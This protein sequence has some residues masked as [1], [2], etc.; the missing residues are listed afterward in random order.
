MTKLNYGKKFSGGSIAS[1][2]YHY[3]RSLDISNFRFRGG[4]INSVPRQ[5]ARW[6]TGQK[7]SNAAKERRTSPEAKHRKELESRISERMRGI[8]HALEM[9]IDELTESTVPDGFVCLV[10]QRDIVDTLEKFRFKFSRLLA[11][12]ESKGA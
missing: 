1:G 7:L 8:E 12:R 4:D 2:T 5:M 10:S 6:K 11:A 3:D 9:T